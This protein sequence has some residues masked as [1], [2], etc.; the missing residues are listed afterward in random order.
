MTTV[1]GID[2]MELNE[3]GNIVDNLR[4]KGVKPQDVEKLVLQKFP[5]AAP[6]QGGGL[7]GGIRATMNQGVRVKHVLYAVGAVVGTVAIL[8]LI[9]MA[10]DVDIPLIHSSA[11]E[12]SGLLE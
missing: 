12:P 4:A 1:N 6:E 3:W 2:N 7:F 8:K 9:G 5:H 11:A 10:F